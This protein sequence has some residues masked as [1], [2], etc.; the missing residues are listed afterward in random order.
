M[1]LQGCAQ[2]QIETAPAVIAVEVKDT[3]PADLLA[4]PAAPAPFPR[5]ATATIPPAVRSALIALATA[6]ADTRDQLLR[7]IRWHEPGACADPRR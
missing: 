7:V 3:P 4:C 5:D 2:R 6:Y 1:T